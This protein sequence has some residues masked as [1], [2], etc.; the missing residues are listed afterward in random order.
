MWWLYAKRSRFD[1]TR[2]ARWSGN[3]GQGTWAHKTAGNRA[4]P[5]WCRVHE[6]LDFKVLATTSSRFAIF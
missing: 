6:I 2:C 3:V 5:R 4:Q 1:E